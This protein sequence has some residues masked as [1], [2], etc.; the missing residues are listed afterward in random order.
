MNIFE[1]LHINNPKL[2]NINN[3]IKISNFILEYVYSNKLNF[4]STISYSKKKRKLEK[5]YLFKSA[6]R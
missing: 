2:D 5:F 4:D 6:F 1:I 3:V